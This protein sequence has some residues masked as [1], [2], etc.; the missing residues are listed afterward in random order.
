MRGI[1]LLRKHGVEH[2]ALVTVNR[3]NV[4]HAL[5]V[6]KHLTGLGLAHLQFIPIVERRSRDSRKVT[7]WSVRPESY[8]AFLCDIFDYW[9]AHDIGRVFVQLF[10]S[11]L[12]VF[13]GGPPS[14]CVY[15]HVCGRALVAE[16]NGDLY[17]CDHFVYPECL[18]GN[19]HRH[20]LAEIV[21]GP[22][23]RAFGES[24]ADD[25][26]SECRGC[27]ALALCG[28]DCPK[29]RIRYTEEDELIS[30]LCPAYRRFFR[31]GAPLL[32]RMASK[33]VSTLDGRIS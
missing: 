13:L 17:A 14:V 27:Q 11:A 10:E 7:H 2:N 4:E 12:A 5:R 18:R 28:G 9:A 22:E 26:A 21:E 3:G 32:G 25:L 23:Q 30:Y 29:H 8:G 6:Y 20:A 16:Y 31:H 19:V 15:S 1:E 24:K 33:I